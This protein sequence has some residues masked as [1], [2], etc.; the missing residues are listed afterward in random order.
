MK[1]EMR[2]NKMEQLLTPKQAV[3]VWLQDTHRYA[4]V[5]EYIKF[6]QGQPESARPIYN[7]YY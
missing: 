6:M 3:I 4:N 2:L 5:V 1:Q 7:P